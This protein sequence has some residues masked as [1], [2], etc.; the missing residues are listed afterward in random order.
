VGVRASNLFVMVPMLVPILNLS[1]L[2]QMLAMMLICASV[3][4]LQ[5]CRIAMVAINNLMKT[6]LGKK[7]LA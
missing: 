5:V 4:I 6:Q 3:N 2:Q 7:A 1:N